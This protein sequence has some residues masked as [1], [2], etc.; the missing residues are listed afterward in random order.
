MHR[1]CDSVVLAHGEFGMEKV[2]LWHQRILY[3]EKIAERK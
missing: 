3:S 2:G 1:V